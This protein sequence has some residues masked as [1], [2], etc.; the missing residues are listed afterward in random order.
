MGDIKQATQE[1]I[2]PKALR[3]E[4]GDAVGNEV[5]KVMQ[6]VDRKNDAIQTVLTAL[7]NADTD[8]R[9]MMIVDAIWRQY[10]QKIA[11]IAISN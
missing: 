3:S 8:E 10:Y 6:V 4:F 2:M 9:R 7:K 5:W 1:A 11:A